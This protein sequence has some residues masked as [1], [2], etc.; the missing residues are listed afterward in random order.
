MFCLILLTT[1]CI[2]KKCLD[3]SDT[4]W[5]GE[6]MYNLSERY[7]KY[8]ESH[9]LTRKRHSE[10]DL[11]IK[12]DDIYRY[13]FGLGLNKL[14]NE[15]VRSKIK[16][17]TIVS[18]ISQSG[19]SIDPE[20][21]Y[22]NYFYVFKNNKLIN[23]FIYEPTTLVMEH[24]QESLES[25]NKMYLKDGNK[26]DGDDMSLLIFTKIKPN[27]SFEISKIIINN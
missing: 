17:D 10:I 13:P 7:V 20:Y 26:L 22:P 23:V 3:N 25:L 19:G 27:W 9:D 14:K 5:K 6:A 4:K 24:S 1:S 11:F 18:V 2:S 8:K 16:F 15:I 21:L 12:I